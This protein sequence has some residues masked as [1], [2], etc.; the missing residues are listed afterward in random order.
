MVVRLV[1]LT[2]VMVWRDGVIG[3]GLF[4]EVGDFGD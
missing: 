2:R 1:A 3:S 4:D